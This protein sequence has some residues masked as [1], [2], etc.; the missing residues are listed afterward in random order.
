MRQ[1]VTVNV[2]GPV[3]LNENDRLHWAPKDRATGQL[4]MLGRSA[5]RKLYAVPG[6]LRVLVEVDVWKGRGG[7][8]DPTNLHPT[9]KALLDGMVDAGALVDDDYRHVDGPH[10][11][12]G[13]VTE[14]LRGRGPRGRGGRVELVFTLT[15]IGGAL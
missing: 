1:Q 2:P 14:R 7:R 6:S 3:V 8:Y 13:G 4:R 12:H 15:G 10:L 5:G 11:K 9:A